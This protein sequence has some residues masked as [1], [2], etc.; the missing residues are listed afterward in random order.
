MTDC[1]RQAKELLVAAPEELSG[2]ADTALARHIRGCPVCTSAA[3]RILAANT[4]LGSVLG[5]PPTVDAGAL[6]ARARSR[7][8][9]ETLN[10]GPL[11][12]KARASAG[13]PWLAIPQWALAAGAAAVVAV[14]IALATIF[15]TAPPSVPPMPAPSAAKAKHPLLLSAPNRR[16]AVFQTGN[17]NITLLWLFKENDDE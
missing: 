12:E 17:P 4:R 8:A 3:Q 1:K 2:E 7:D 9:Q 5:S 16:V 10:A 6:I 13:R 11:G 15:E 14:G